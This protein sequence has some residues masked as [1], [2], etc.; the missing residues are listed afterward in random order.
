MFCAADVAP[1]CDDNR[2]GLGFAEFVA[3]TRHY[4]HLAWAAYG[5]SGSMPP[6]MGELLELLGHGLLPSHGPPIEAWVPKPLPLISDAEESDSSTGAH[7]R[8]NRRLSR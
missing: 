7:V 5:S 1:G 2:G 3:A 6:N 8:E 4:L